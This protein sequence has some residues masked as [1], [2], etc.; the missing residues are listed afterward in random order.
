MGS[1]ILYGLGT[2]NRDLPGFIT[3]SPTLGH[4]GVQNWSSA[5]LPG[6]FQGSPVGRAGLP[7]KDARLRHLDDPSRL[8]DARA[9]DLALLRE[10]NRVA[11]DPAS[12]D[13]MLEA[14]VEAFELAFRMQAQAPDAFDISKETTETKK[15]YGIDQP[16]T[17]DFGRQCL[18][19]RRL[20]ERGVRF[21]QCS[22]SYK[23][24][25]HEQLKEMH[26]KNAAEVDLPIAGLL[27]DL[28]GRG[29]LKDTLVV[30]AGEFGRTPTMQGNKGRDHN[31]HGF[32]IWMAG[33]GVKGGFSY[34]ET[35][36]YGFYAVRDKV[37]VHDFH[38]TLLALLGLD[39]EK[40][41]WR[42]AGRDFR[43]TDVSGRVVT[44]LFAS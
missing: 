7:T 42:H 5:F 21:V 41:T 26:E 35:D 6:S 30:W 29:L 19:A 31:P 32:T 2:E 43:L 16:G 10:L 38:A 9:D 3:I 25:Q 15:L 28:K 22:H 44:E 17:D 12:H 14:Q 24:D 40:L 33:G 18:L 39:H 1:W 27:A 4:G 23:W 13:P 37:H 34:G 8:P 11:K 20:S 36:D